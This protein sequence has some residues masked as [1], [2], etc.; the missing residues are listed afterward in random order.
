MLDAYPR[1]LIKVQINLSNFISSK[2]LNAKRVTDLFIN[3]ILLMNQ[4]LP[5]VV[6]PVNLR[7]NTSEPFIDELETLANCKIA[8]EYKMGTR[9]LFIF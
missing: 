8:L 9:E 6:I 2:T 3:Y 7:V 4:F 5:I 1:Q